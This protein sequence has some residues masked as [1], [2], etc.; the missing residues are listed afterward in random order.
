MS[1]CVIYSFPG[2]TNDTLLEKFH[3]NH[4]SSSDY[5]IMPMRRESTFSI[6]HYAGT[7]KYYIHVSYNI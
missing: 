2:A 5:Y 3:Q 1:V 7:V 6:R 4:K